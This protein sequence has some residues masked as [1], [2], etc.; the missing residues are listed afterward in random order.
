ML[1]LWFSVRVRYADESRP[2]TSLHRWPSP[3]L[4]C[5]SRRLEVT[6]L[7]GRG[8]GRAEVR[9]SRSDRATR[10]VRHRCKLHESQRAT[11]DCG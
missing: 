4:P 7:R 5:Q 9:R 1:A 3:I 8:W 10:H 2:V 6:T 11:R